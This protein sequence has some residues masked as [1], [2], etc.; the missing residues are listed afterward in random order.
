MDSDNDGEVDLTDEDYNGDGIDDQ[1]GLPN[2]DYDGI[3]EDPYTKGNAGST[4]GDNT[5]GQGNSNSNSQ[6][7]YQ[8]KSSSSSYTTST[9]Y[10]YSGKSQP[11]GARARQDFNVTSQSDLVGPETSSHPKGASTVLDPETS[12]LNGHYYTLLAGTQLVDGL[13]ILQDGQ[14]HCT[15]YPTT[16]MTV[17][18]FNTLFRTLPW[19]GGN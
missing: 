3:D 17:L 13:G 5:Q 9:V 10:H 15:I 16:Q 4:K 14:N 6:S 19:I 7:S 18:M 8:M 1:T 12:G 2:N 11:R